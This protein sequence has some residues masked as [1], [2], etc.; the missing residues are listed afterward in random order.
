MTPARF[1]VEWERCRPYLESAL[2]HSHD[3]TLDR[4]KESVLAGD[5]HFWP[6]VDSAMV[7][8]LD[9]G[10]RT[11]HI[12]LFGGT[13]ERLREMLPTIEAFGRNLG[14]TGITLTGRRGW[15]RTTLARDLD[16]YPVA[17]LMRKDLPHE[18][19]IE[20]QDHQ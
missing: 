16:Y 20:H 19:R 7:T 13:M 5:A 14:C 12:R 4:I 2:A 9:N 10:G 18:L 8:E 15:E 3:T 17:T 11:L 6:A 1:G